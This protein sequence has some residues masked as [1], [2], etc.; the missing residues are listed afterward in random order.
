LT[1]SNLV[2]RSVIARQG[3]SVVRLAT[4]RARVPIAIVPQLSR[5]SLVSALA[6][7]L[8]FTAFLALTVSAA[9]PLVA[10]VIGYTLGMALHYMLSSRFVFDAYATNKIHARL[11]GEFALSG[12]VGIGV[13]AFV[14]SLATQAGLAALPAK[15][16]A[17]P[18]SFLMV[19]A[20]RRSV[21]FVR[22]DTDRNNELQHNA[23][24]RCLMALGSTRETA[25][26][27][28]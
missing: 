25:R 8:D 26:S 5:Y 23:R 17:A 10:G 21:V 9:S 19:F 4:A 27:E 12:I 14:I 16:L 11:L 18:A 13:T 1:L 24:R 6:L 20:L 2:D 7:G 3:R 22:A 15:V 28:I